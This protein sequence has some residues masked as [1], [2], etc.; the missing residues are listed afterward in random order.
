MD[1][2]FILMVLLLVV[3]GVLGLGMYF[4]PQDPRTVEMTLRGKLHIVLAGMASFFT[5][6]SMLLSGLSFSKEL[7]IKSF[8]L[9]SYISVIIT[10]ITGGTAAASVANNSALGG[11]FERLVIGSFIQWVFVFALYLMMNFRESI[12]NTETNII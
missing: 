6:L 4:C 10:F 9:Y 12:A 2:K 8:A 1:K 3:I 7:K 11:L 5:M